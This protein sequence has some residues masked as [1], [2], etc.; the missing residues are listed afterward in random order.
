M[1]FPRVTGLSS[2]QSGRWTDALGLY[3]LSLGCHIN[4]SPLARHRHIATSILP[5]KGDGDK[6]TM[7][8]RSV[9]VGRMK[10]CDKASGYGCCPDKVRQAR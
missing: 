5:G 6:G 3:H 10:T 7:R 1:N 2:S 9:D 4:I 8:N